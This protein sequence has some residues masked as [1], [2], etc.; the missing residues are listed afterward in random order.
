MLN[1]ALYITAFF[2]F[3]LCPL[4]NAQNNTFVQKDNAMWIDNFREFRN[5]VYQRDIIKVKSF[6]DF[7]VMNINNEIWYLV[8]ADN[9]TRL[10]KIS[11]KIKPFTEQDFDK[12]FDILFSKK[13]ITCINKIKTEELYKN[14]EFQTIE[15]NEN[16]KNSYQMYATVNKKDN[17]LQ[18]NMTSKTIENDEKEEALDSTESS[19]IYCFRLIKNRTLK[20]FQIR[21][22]G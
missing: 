17:T 10:S 19:I 15:F 6:I 7:P 21:L 9:E 8:Y 5:A 3:I 14:G 22:A 12:Y 2:L 16:K 18:L 1:K 4:V 20:F 13:F 11:D